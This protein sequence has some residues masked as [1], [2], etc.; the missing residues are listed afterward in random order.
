MGPRK[1]ASPP[2]WSLPHTPGDLQKAA[3]EY[4]ELSEAQKTI[5]QEQ[6]RTGVAAL[7]QKNRITQDQADRLLALVGIVGT[8]LNLKGTP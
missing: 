8:T 1:V 4:A 6:T 2:V 7:L 5:M 3:D